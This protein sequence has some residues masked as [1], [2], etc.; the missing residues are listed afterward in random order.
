MAKLT[1]TFKGRPIQAYQFE[2]GETVSIGR[3]EGNEICIDSLAVAPVHAQ[4]RFEQEK[5]T[6]HQSSSEFPLRVNNSQTSE[7]PLNH[8]DQITIGKHIL[9]FTE[10]TT[11]L[12]PASSPEV[13]RE[14]EDDLEL[15][16]EELKNA[17]QQT[18]A[19]LQILNGKNIGR[20]ITLKKG[21]TRLGKPDTGVA[22][23]ARRKDGFYISALDG[24]PLIRVNT[25]LI[26]NRSVKLNEGD[27]LEI[28]KTSMQ[29][30]SSF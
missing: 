29:F 5:S 28:E 19:Q 1:L 26:D 8:G 22:V 16:N 2:T 9:Y 7:Q 3:N 27:T 11:L 20:I 13:S 6:I 25:E 15:L 17:A 24:N 18:D 23:I 10:D 12:E 21:L 30:F 4:I 14:V